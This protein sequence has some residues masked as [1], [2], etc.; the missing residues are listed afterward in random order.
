MM[1]YALSCNNNPVAV[2]VNVCVCV[3]V[4]PSHH[5][6]MGEHPSTFLARLGSS[7]SSADLQAGARSPRAWCPSPPSAGSRTK[8]SLHEVCATAGA[9][10][11]GRTSW[12]LGGFHGFH[13]NE[14]CFPMN[15]GVHWISE[16]PIIGTHVP[17]CFCSRDVKHRHEDSP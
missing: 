3:Q 9:T 1:L 10:E 4:Q 12:N 14:S 15:H 6:G 5:R 17:Q 13:W 8:I 7:G 11:W 16:S 2:W